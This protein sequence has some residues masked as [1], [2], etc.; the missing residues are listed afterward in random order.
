LKIER[1]SWKTQLAKLFSSNTV[2][3][4]SQHCKLQ[5]GDVALLTIGPRI[6]AV[7]ITFP[8]VLYY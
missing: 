5:E 3:N 8:F 1:D 7:S 2:E 4:I 6:D